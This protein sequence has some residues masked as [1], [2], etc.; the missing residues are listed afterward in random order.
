MTEN[1]FNV[2]LRASSP[3]GVYGEKYTRE[4]HA[5]RFARPN[6]RVCLHA[7]TSYTSHTQDW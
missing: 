1:M 4:K 5:A 3:L 6:G 2:S 7:G